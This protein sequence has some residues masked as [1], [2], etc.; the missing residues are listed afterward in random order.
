MEGAPRHYGYSRIARRRPSAPQVGT[1]TTYQRGRRFIR[2]VMAGLG[3]HEAWTH[4]LL[5]PGDH[6]RAGM[7]GGVTVANPLV[8]DEKVLRQSL[9]PG[10]LHA[11]AA[12]AARRQ[13][14]LRLF[15]VGHVFPPPDDSRVER[16]LQ[17]RVEPVIGE[18][19]LLAVALARSDDDAMSAAA[20]WSVL[21]DALRVAGVTLTQGLESWPGEA[22]AAGLHPTRRGLLVTGDGIRLGAVGEVDPEVLLAFGLDERRR[23]GWLQLDLELLLGS[24]ARRGDLAEA[25]SRFP[26]S[27][28]DLAFVVDDAVPAAAVAET[29]QEAGGDLLEFVRL[30]DVYRGPGTGTGTRSLAF[31]LRFCALDHTLTDE[32]VQQVR[33]RCIA[34]VTEDHGAVLRG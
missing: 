2:E 7:A 26:S 23:V 11:L 33:T 32:E 5:A 30:F 20:A 18:R 34:R 27:D 29:L 17:G 21:D 22:T 28:I 1:L 12:N 16:A 19:E 24:T 6:E 15:E 3:A 14:D 31:R 10:M 9:L 8:P 4:S 25:V 13:E